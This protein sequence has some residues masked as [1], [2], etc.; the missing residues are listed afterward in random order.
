LAKLSPYAELNSLYEKGLVQLW[1]D[2]LG[3]KKPQITA[4]QKMFNTSLPVK[5]ADWHDSYYG[6]VGRALGFTQSE[7]QHLVAAN[8]SGLSFAVIAALIEEHPPVYSS[9]M[10]P[11]RKAEARAFC[12][13]VVAAIKHHRRKTEP[14]NYVY[15]FFNVPSAQKK[16]FVGA[17][18]YDSPNVAAFSGIDVLPVNPPPNPYG[19][20]KP[21]KTWVANKS[22]Q[23]DWD[24]DTQQMLAI[25]SNPPKSY[26]TGKEQDSLDAVHLALEHGNTTFLHGL[27]LPPK[28]GEMAKL[29]GIWTP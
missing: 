2:V 10:T 6:Q 21:S 26:T 25:M 8:D 28:P 14:D 7:I 4:K 24:A 18:V 19:I 12:E 9:A 5:K 20:I 27:V 29:L 22:A 13:N 1:A 23:H 15:D 11:T 16:Y 3:N 17:D